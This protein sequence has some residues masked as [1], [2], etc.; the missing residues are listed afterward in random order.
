MPEMHVCRSEDVPDGA[1]RI[2]NLGGAEF[3]L[4]RHK[5][6]FYAY[7]NVCP[8]QG[9]PVCEGL[10]IPQ[11][12]DRIDADGRYLGQI[13]DENDLHI[14]CPWHGYEFH[15]TN[16]EHVADHKLKLEKFPVSEREGNVYVTI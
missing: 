15:L 12:V 4:I 3:G 8:H 16:G 7:R 1:T 11:I 2:V 10:R 13:F 14:V 6:K 9:G 5:G